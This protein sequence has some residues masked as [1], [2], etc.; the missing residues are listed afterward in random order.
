MGLPVTLLSPLTPYKTGCKPFVYRQSDTLAPLN[1]KNPSKHNINHILHMDFMAAVTT[2]I[3]IKETSEV[4][5]VLLRLFLMVN[6]P[7]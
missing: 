4:A 2:R 7:K 6:S 5:F 1:A 3:S